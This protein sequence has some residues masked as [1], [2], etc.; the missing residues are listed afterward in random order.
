[1]D[2]I[3]EHFTTRYLPKSC[4]S[5]FQSNSWLHVICKQKETFCAPGEADGDIPIAESG[6]SPNGLSPASA[7]VL[8]H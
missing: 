3:L 2:V 7:R 5:S 1:M 8:M 4:K 6:L